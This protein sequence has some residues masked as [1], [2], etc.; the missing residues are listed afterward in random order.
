MIQMIRRMSF[1]EA[2]TAAVLLAV[3]VA[4]VATSCTLYTPTGERPLTLKE[5]V[6]QVGGVLVGVGQELEFAIKTGTLKADSETAKNLVRSYEA[7]FK[8]YRQAAAFAIAENDPEA[9]R[10]R[11]ELLRLIDSLRRDLTAALVKP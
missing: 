7:A 4:S 1:A 8:L 5:Q 10:A 9:G 11:L 6:Y 2:T 3:M